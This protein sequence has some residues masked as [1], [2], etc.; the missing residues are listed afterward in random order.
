MSHLSRVSAVHCSN[1][2]CQ[3][4]LSFSFL[5]GNNIVPA[6]CENS[7]VRYF[8][9]SRQFACAVEMI[10]YSTALAFAPFAVLLKSQIFLPTANGRIAF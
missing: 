3:I 9:A 8:S 4:L 6:G 5:H 1:G 7:S 10:E 2:I